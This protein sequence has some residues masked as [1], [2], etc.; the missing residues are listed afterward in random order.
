M[1]NNFKDWYND[2]KGKYILFFGFYLI[3][4]IF[5]GIYIRAVK[6]NKP[7][8]EIKEEEKQVEKI[9]TYDISRLTSNDYSYIIEI[10]DNEELLNFNGTKSNIDYANYE[11]KYF[12]D[13]Y[14][15]NQLLKR[16]KLVD[17]NNNILTYELDNKEINDI[18]LTNKKE[19]INK[20]MIYVDDKTE[21]NKISLDLSNYLDKDI[22]QINISYT[23]GDVNENSSS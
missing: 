23:V 8:E 19:G 22:Y 15:I 3:F 21:V 7:V 12:L 18:L 4:F 9:T 11:N 5:F 17:S 16:S 13:I 2:K 14:N 20:I 1:I 6:D 10:I